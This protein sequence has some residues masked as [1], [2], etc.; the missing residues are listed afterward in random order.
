MFIES[1]VVIV[2][3]SIFFYGTVQIP[4]GTIGVV[5]SW[6]SLQQGILEEGRNFEV[7]PWNRI[8]LVDIL[9]QTDDIENIGCH[10][11]EGTEIRF[12]RITVHNQLRM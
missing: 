2:I 11:R 5:Y 1:A 4:T 7:K 3:S 9:P 8:G 12:P 10:S 6:K